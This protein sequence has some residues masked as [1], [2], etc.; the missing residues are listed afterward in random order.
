MSTC[1]PGEYLHFPVLLESEEESKL[2][3]TTSM[4]IADNPK[5]R[6]YPLNQWGG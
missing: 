3:L 2:F 5:I 6:T 4:K 1:D